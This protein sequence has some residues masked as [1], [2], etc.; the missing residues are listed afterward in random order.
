MRKSG[1]RFIDGTSWVFDPY[2]TVCLRVAV[3]YIEFPWQFYVAACAGNADP[4]R[5]MRCRDYDSQPLGY[6]REESEQIGQRQTYVDDGRPAVG[7]QRQLAAHRSD[8]V[9]LRFQ[10]RRI[11]IF[12]DPDIVAYSSDDNVHVI[13]DRDDSSLGCRFLH[14]GVSPAVGSVDVGPCLAP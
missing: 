10:F 12:D 8:S 6:E 4:C 13:R 9:E 14:D 1:C 3:R 11:R 5:R 2:R 7:Q